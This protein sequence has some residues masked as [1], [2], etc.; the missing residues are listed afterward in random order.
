M[1]IFY[2]HRDPVLAAQM[3]HDKHVVK[4]TLESAQ[5]LSTVY[6]RY[7]DESVRLYRPTHAAHPSVLWA[8]DTIDQYTWTARHGLALAQEYTNRYGR[9]HACTPMLQALQTPPRGL[10]S[11]GWQQP[12]QCMPPELQVAGDAIAGYR[13]YYLARKVVQSTWTRREVPTFVKEDTDMAKKN[14]AAKTAAA[15]APAEDVTIPTGEATETPA[16]EAAPAPAAAPEKKVPLAKMRGPRGVPETAKIT[17]LASVNP[18][19]PGSK[20]HAAFALYTTGMT[21]GEFCDKVDALVVDGASQKGMGTPH[22]VY[23]T[24]HGFVSI[25][26]YT[27]PGGVE[28]PKP[29]APPKE[30]V[31]K[32]PKAPKATPAENKAAA[33]EA[34]AATSENAAAVEEATNSEIME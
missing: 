5:I 25:E 8:G 13:Q 19:R 10:E 15:P 21:V 28:P 32:A 12:P 30:K 20:A 29:K 22:L 3:L 24:K 33:A 27:V 6:H 17:V 14:P 11:G 9:V 1:N 16:A 2:L 34:A 31:A 26:G 7:G 23:D 18:K 4:M